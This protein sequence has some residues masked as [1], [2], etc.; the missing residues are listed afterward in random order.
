[1]AKYTFDQ[2]KCNVAEIANRD[3]Y[4]KEFIFEL[5]AAYG[6]ATSAIN[7]LK[8]GAIDKSTDPNA[9]L[10]KGVLYFKVFPQGTP[11]E[12]KVEEMGSESLF[13]R[14]EPRYIVATDLHHIVAKDTIKHTTLDIE[15]KDID[16]EV[17]FFTDGLVM[18]LTKVVLMN[19]PLIEVQPTR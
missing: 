18:K 12:E 11:L 4:T 10:Q 13:R 14:Y 3:S 6:R 15:I 19:R 7:Q 5:M 16:N 2:V 17:A 9:L 8:S 1:M